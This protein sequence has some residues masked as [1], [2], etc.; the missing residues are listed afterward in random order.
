MI[1]FLALLAVAIVL[2]YVSIRIIVRRSANK[3]WQEAL[4]DK[5]GRKMRY[6]EKWLKDG[7]PPGF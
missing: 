7:P 1:A 5:S 4:D 2:V 3:M 6:I